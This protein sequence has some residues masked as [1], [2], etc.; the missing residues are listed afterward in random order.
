MKSRAS[1]IQGFRSPSLSNT[2]PKTSHHHPPPAFPWEPSQRPHT[3][4]TPE[5]ST[6]TPPSGQAGAPKPAGQTGRGR[7]P[8]GPS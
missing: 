1:K 5:G 2:R 7:K 4:G 8:S 6:A 3:L